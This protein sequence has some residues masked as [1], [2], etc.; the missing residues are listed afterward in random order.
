MRIGEEYGH[1][2]SSPDTLA[3][4]FGDTENLIEALRYMAYRTVLNDAVEAPDKFCISLKI[5]PYYP[6]VMDIRPGYQPHI[7]NYNIIDDA[8]DTWPEGYDE[9]FAVTK[10]KKLVRADE[11]LYGT[12]EI[13]SFRFILPQEEEQNG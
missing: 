6:L 5:D 3:Q 12:G 2:N 13:V 9:M 7:S 10:A 1:P 8:E 11:V 4:E